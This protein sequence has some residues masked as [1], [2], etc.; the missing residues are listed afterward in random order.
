MPGTV[1]IAYDGSDDAQHAI[2]VARDVLSAE[3]AVVVHVRV[4]PQP[5]IIGADPEGPQSES[6][7]DIH[8]QQADRTV[9]EGVDV[10]SRAGFAAEPVVETADSMTGVWKAILDMA[11]EHGAAAI[12]TGHR[13]L[14]RLQSA[15]LGSVSNGLVNHAHVPVLV[16]PRGRA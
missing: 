2:A 4:V 8:R 10:A 16:V 5:P 14:S 12:V 1:V 15:L 9:A 11:E 13:G 6:P 3:R 7:D